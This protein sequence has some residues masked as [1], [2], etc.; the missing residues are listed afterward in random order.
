MYYPARACSQIDED[1]WDWMNNI[2]YCLRMSLMVRSLLPCVRIRSSSS[3]FGWVSNHEIVNESSSMS[4]LIVMSYRQYE[5]SVCMSLYESSVKPEMSINLDQ[6]IVNEWL[7]D[8]SLWDR[9]SL[10]QRINDRSLSSFNMAHQWSPRAARRDPHARA[11][12]PRWCSMALPSLHGQ[13]GRKADVIERP[14]M[15]KNGPPTPG[16]C[17]NDD[18]DW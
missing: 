3:Q 6:S 10:A 14:S 18:D 7:W 17:R 13:P 15:R 4:S 11:H 2:T 9:Q 12:V 16:Q 1:G 5:S 8:R